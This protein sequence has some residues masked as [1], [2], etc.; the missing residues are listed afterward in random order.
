MKRLQVK[1]NGKKKSRV[2][3]REQFRTKEDRQ[4]IAQDPCP[5]EKVSVTRCLSALKSS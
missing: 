2:R 3:P 1:T 5:Q 4:K